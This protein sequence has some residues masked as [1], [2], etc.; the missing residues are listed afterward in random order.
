MPTWTSKELIRML[1][2]DGWIQLAQRGTSHVH[3]THT[4]KKGRVTVPA[5]KKSI[6]QGTVRSIY[7][8][9]GW[10]WATRKR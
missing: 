9:A 7:R 8:Q 2:D 3:F 6:S 1:L 4:T 10:D 5:A